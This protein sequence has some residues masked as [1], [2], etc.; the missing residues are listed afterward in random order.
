MKNKYEIAALKALGAS[1]KALQYYRD[2]DPIDIWQYDTGAYE[3]TGAIPFYAENA[4]VLLR[5]LDSLA[6]AFGYV[7]ADS[8]FDAHQ[9]APALYD[10]GWRAEDAE[11]LKAEYDLTDEE[12]AALVAELEEIAANT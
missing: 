12:T 7:G 5:K 11:Q 4:S 1:A 2:A 10:G 9:A 8:A 3:I 6:D